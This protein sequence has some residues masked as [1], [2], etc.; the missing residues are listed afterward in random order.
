MSNV[1]HDAWE[2]LYKGLRLLVGDTGSLQDRLCDAYCQELHLLNVSGVPKDI[3][4]DFRRFH[5]AITREQPTAD[6][7]SA[8]ATIDKM[9][10]E[11]ATELAYAVVSMFDTVCRLQGSTQPQRN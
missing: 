4:E 3:Q 10:T 8:K 11:E 9:T 2:K 7:G 1:L 5:E 6:E